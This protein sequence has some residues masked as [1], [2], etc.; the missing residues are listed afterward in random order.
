[1]IGMDSRRTY[2]RW[3]FRDIIKKVNKLNFSV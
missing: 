3:I 1:M 2:L